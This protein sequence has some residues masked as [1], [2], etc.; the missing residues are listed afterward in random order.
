MSSDSESA[1]H[2]GLDVV[3]VVLVVIDVVVDLPR[4]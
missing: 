4:I 2:D 1:I 3:V